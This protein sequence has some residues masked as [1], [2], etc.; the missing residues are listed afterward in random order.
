[1]CWQV[2]P[3]IIVQERLWRI[4]DVGAFGKKVV[5]CVLEAHDGVCVDLLQVRFQ[6]A[7]LSVLLSELLPQIFRLLE[8]CFHRVR[9]LTTADL[10]LWWWTI[11]VGHI[12]TWPIVFKGVIPSTIKLVNSP[13]EQMSCISNLIVL[14]Q[15]HL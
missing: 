10:V 3:V 9:H 6:V 12:S 14:T 13:R 5:V 1:M 2:W 7:N 4:V 15:I 8:Q 11:G